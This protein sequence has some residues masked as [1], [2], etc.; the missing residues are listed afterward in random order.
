MTRE[1]IIRMAVEAG[2][3]DVL[4]PQAAVVRFALIVAA[5]EREECA[6]VCEKEHADAMAAAKAAERCAVTVRARGEEK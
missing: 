6:K 3:D 1:D 5:A 2:V 4:T